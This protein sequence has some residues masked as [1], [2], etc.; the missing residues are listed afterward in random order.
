MDKLIEDHKRWL[1]IV[2]FFPCFYG[3]CV[4]FLALN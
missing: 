3:L 4:L 2:H 1:K